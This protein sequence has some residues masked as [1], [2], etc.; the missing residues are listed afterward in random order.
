MCTGYWVNRSN[1]AFHWSF[2]KNRLLSAL[3]SGAAADHDYIVVRTHESASVAISL[4]FSDDYRISK[5]DSVGSGKRGLNDTQS[6][7]HFE[8][9]AS[10]SRSAG[11]GWSSSR[12]THISSVPSPAMWI[13]HF[14][15]LIM[16][17]T[18]AL[19]LA[20]GSS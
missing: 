3:V 8:G 4:G 5:A 18:A 2:R 12:T 19:G 15:P 17:L 7:C 20:A 1:L 14:V 9:D 6:R 10:V 16:K 11:V 13:L